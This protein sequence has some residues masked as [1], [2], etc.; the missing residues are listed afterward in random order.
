MFENHN[1]RNTAPIRESTSI[2]PRARATKFGF[3]SV[4]D[5]RC[6][7]RALDRT[8]RLGDSV[9]QLRKV[10]RADARDGVPPRAR[11]E[12]ARAAAGVVARGDVVERAR[13]RV[14]ERVQEAE[15][16]QARVEK[17][18]A[19]AQ[20]QEKKKAIHAAVEAALTE[21]FPAGVNEKEVFFM[22]HVQQGEGL[23]A[24]RESLPFPLAYLPHR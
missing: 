6:I 17:E 21:G 2:I 24:D 4:P 10:G 5:G 12:A 7:I 9:A 11:A 20:S 1:P 8:S 3:A 13:V 14:D 18:E 19:V 16:R 15:R 22:D 23:A